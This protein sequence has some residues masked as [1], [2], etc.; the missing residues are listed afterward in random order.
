MDIHNIFLQAHRGFAYLEILL[1]II[2]VLALIMA[3]AKGSYIN[4]FLKKITMFVMIVFHVQFL[5]GIIMLLGT[6]GFMNAL[7]EGGM[8]AIMKNSELRFKFIE[9]P[10]SML[11]AAILMTVVN[12]KMK[13]SEKITGVI[14]V[15]SVLALV[16]FGYA[17]PWDR[18]MGN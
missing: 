13:S 12:R 3:F 6:S 7:N 18:L 9:H 15:L 2:F 16:L 11:I 17:L 8:G 14:I 10:F 5:V 1:V 4:N